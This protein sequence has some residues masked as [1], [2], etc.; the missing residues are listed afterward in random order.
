MPFKYKYDNITILNY[1]LFHPHRYDNLTDKYYALK[2]MSH[3][4][5]GMCQKEWQEFFELPP[6]EQSLE[7]GT[8][9]LAR[10]FQPHVDVSVKQVCREIITELQDTITAL[11]FFH[12]LLFAAFCILVHGPP[13]LSLFLSLFLSLYLDSWGF[14]IYWEIWWRIVLECNDFSS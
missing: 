9:M 13:H 4:H 2:V 12:L 10:W 1:I 7:V 3:V 11:Y 8:M 14:V 6:R 5:Q